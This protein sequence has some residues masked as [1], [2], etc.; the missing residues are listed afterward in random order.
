M[1]RVRALLVVAIATLATS[2]RADGVRSTVEQGER[3]G[4][5]E[6]RAGGGIDS[7][8]LHDPQ[9]TAQGALLRVDMTGEVEP[10]R[11]LR[12]S[13]T[14]WFDEHLPQYDL[15]EASVQPLVLYRR[16]LLPH[17]ALRIGSASEYHRELMTWVE[18]TI[19]THGAV[20]LSDAAEHLAI[21]LEI[22]LGRFDVEIGTQGHAKYVWGTDVYG[23]YGADGSV[24]L[25]WTPFHGF[26]ARV[27]YLFL[28][29]DVNGLQLLNL[30][31]QESGVHRDLTLLTHQLDVT[32]RARPLATLDLMLRYEFDSI[33]D[34]FVGYLTG[35]EQRVT[36]GLR[37]D[38]ERRWV[39]DFSGRLVAR[40]YPLRILPTVDNQVSDL[41]VELILDGEA[42]LSRHVGLFA[43][44]VFA[45]EVANPFGTIYLQHVAVVGVAT[46]AGVTW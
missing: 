42:W 15:N 29:E 6:V 28:Y 40:D 8:V 4:T 11:D 39:I 18:G 3:T 45:G 36:T 37:W 10:T 27:R 31:G 2:A 20:L 38:D 30:G 33:T 12:L 43:R 25:R 5:S 24:A 22:P 7:N 41:E 44:Y 17:L 23:V 26:A 21:G 9:A 34:N 35:T 19:L 14:G 16:L 1:K 32:L 46:R 13:L